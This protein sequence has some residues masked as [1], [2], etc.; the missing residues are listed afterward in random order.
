MKMMRSWTRSVLAGIALLGLAAGTGGTQNT[1][2]LPSTIPSASQSGNPLDRGRDRE[3]SPFGNPA[4]KQAKQRNDDRQR[5]LVS[6]TERLLALATSLHEDVAKTDK[7]VLSLDVVR[8]ADEI[9]KLARS[10]KE[11]MKG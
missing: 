7:N 6:D 10:V 4:E 9:E 2:P 8:R 5:R 1:G 3:M 11:R